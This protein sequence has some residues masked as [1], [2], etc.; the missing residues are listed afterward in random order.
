MCVNMSAEFT[1]CT[2]KGRWKNLISWIYFYNLFT[3]CKTHKEKYTIV[4]A[5]SMTY[6]KRS[7]LDEESWFSLS[8][9]SVTI[10]P[11]CRCCRI[12]CY[13]L[14][15]MERPTVLR[16]IWA[17]LSSVFMRLRHA[18]VA[19]PCCVTFAFVNM[20]HCV[21]LFYSWRAFGLFPAVVRNT[22]A[23]NILLL[24]LKNI[25]LAEI[26]YLRA[27][28]VMIWCTLQY[29]CEMSLIEHMCAFLLW[30]GVAGT[31]SIY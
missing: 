7:S 6:H 20:P 1:I 21:P 4:N 19:S 30:D 16:C 25:Y 2:G 26:V 3:G 9:R 18:A 12:S 22:I 24:D 17:P 10:L 28:G 8:A 14:A 15:F 29:P 23:E 13:L 11:R 27:C 31:E 5:F